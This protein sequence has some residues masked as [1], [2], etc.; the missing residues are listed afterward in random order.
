MKQNVHPSVHRQIH[1]YG[2]V[3]EKMEQYD[4]VVKEPVL[5]PAGTAQNMKI[6]SESGETRLSYGKEEDN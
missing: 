3:R 6:I 4:I 2:T 1:Q 5:T